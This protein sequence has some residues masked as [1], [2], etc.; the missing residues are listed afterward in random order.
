MQVESEFITL[1]VAAVGA[2]ATVVSALVGLAIATPE[3][4]QRLLQWAK[5]G[6]ARSVYATVT[7]IMAWTFHE[8]WT[9]DYVIDSQFVLLISNLVCMA[10]IWLAGGAWAVFFRPLSLEISALE[11]NRDRAVLDTLKALSAENAA[12][13]KR[14][15]ELEESLAGR[16][17]RKRE[18][19]SGFS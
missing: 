2:V 4:R 18:A 14:V 10:I 6:T 8:I 12:L 15:T 19:P 13:S 7:A 17:R 1:V 3:Q 9:N 5:T 16:T 11:R